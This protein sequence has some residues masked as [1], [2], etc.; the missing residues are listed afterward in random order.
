[1]VRVRYSFGSRHTGRISNIKKK[2]AKYPQ[3][4]K[5][6]IDISDIVLEVLDAR[7]IEGTGLDE[8]FN[9]IVNHNPVLGK[10]ASS[11]PELIVERMASFVGGEYFE[12][13]FEKMK[14]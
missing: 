7:Y 6:V 9:L 10:L 5:D 3:V 4:M 2:R 1:M 13:L 14:E 12:F 8:D 11:T